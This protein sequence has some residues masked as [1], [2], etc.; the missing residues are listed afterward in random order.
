[1]AVDPCRMRVHLL[2]PVL[3]RPRLRL[4][5]ALGPGSSDH[6][7][8]SPER[9]ATAGH[10]MQPI[11]IV[12]KVLVPPRPPDILHRERLVDFLHEHIDR[13]LTLVSAPAGYGKTTLLVDFAH[14]TDLAVCWYTLD[15]ID[16]DSRVFAE[17]LVASL[18]HR[19]PEFGE[20]TRRAL[21]AHALPDDNL[22]EIVGTLVN[23]MVHTIPQWFVIILDDFHHVEHA[24]GVTDLLSTFLNYQPEHCHLIIASRTI[25]STLPFIHLAARRQV[26]GLGQDDLRF[27]PEE[28][29]L[30]FLQS[31]QPQVSPEE[32]HR[33]A[34]ESDG[35]IT[36]I[37]LTSHAL[38]RGTLEILRHA[39]TSAQPIHDYLSGEVLDAQDPKLRAFVLASSTLEEMSPA[40]CR[41]A[42]G[43]D[44]A[45]RLLGLL[46][47][48]NLFAERVVEE[49]QYRLRHHAFFRE[50]LQERLE[51]ESPETFRRLHRRAA[52]WYAE[53]GDA[54]RA[55]R[56]Y[57]ATGDAE[58]AAQLIS[59]EASTLL[60]TG[61]L[62]TLVAWA[63]RFPVETL[64]RYPSLAL[65]AAQA[66]LRTGRDRQASTWLDLAEKE[67][68][69]RDEKDLLT[70]TIST[71]ALLHYT[72]ARYTVGM[73][74]AEQALSLLSPQQPLVCE[75]TVE[76][77]R[78]KG[79]CQLRLGEYK[80]AE[81]CLRLALEGSREIRDVY[82]EVNIRQALGEC[83]RWMGRLGDGV[84]EQRAVVETCRQ[85][86]SPAALP[87]A[88]T[89]LAQS[90][91]SI[92]EHTEALNT[93][94]EAVDAAR[95]AGP[96]YS[97]A[98]TLLGLGEMLRDLGDPETAV[99][100]LASGLEIARD[101]HND[102]LSAYGHEA[103]ALARLYLG[104]ARQALRPAWEA[105]SVARQQGT[106]GQIGRCQAT[107]G[108]IQTE[109]G[110]VEKGIESLRA[111]CTVLEQTGAKQEAARA[112]LLLAY[113][114]L[115]G[116]Q[117][118]AALDLSSLAIESY[119]DGRQDHALLIEGQPV[120]PLLEMA[121]DQGIGG[122]ALAVVL[123]RRDHLQDLAQQA[124]RRAETATTTAPS[125]RA[126]GFGI[127][128]VERDGVM[129][130]TSDWATTTARYLFFY[131]LS[132]PCRTR[133]Q[134]GA[135]L[136]PDLR[137]TRLPG[138][139]HNTK[140][141]MQQALGTNP[142]VYEQQVYALQDDLRVWYDVEEF[143]RLL[144]RARR[145]APFKAARYMRQ[146][147]A[148]YAGDFLEDCWA[149][150]CVARRETLRRCYL[151]TIARLADWLL[152]H[153]RLEEVISL[154]QKGLETDSLREDFHCKLMQAYALSG[155]PEEAV[156]QYR[157]C[158]RIL[159]REL[160]SVPE[161][162]TEEL[163]IAIR[164]GL[165]RPADG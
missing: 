141:R 33:L 8:T 116:G 89:Q 152:E 18:A 62:E 137:A 58:A 38:G 59:G 22:V 113:A 74:I 108:L 119:L 11:P 63:Q 37:L 40:L 129:I 46:A 48:R 144:E 53:Q 75:A 149:D 12:T 148:L 16:R 106:M 135:D 136:W 54:D 111:A 107:L 52:V 80:D 45:D 32:A 51:T 69:K 25:P 3:L 112:R 105:A 76:A 162:E 93:Q 26:A 66:A 160:G 7:R 156:A 56:H 68:R 99:G 115:R 92:G 118:Q 161:P 131:L 35:W 28:I 121:V 165:F 47:Q 117:Q 159:K 97:Q 82:R 164:Q 96:G 9:L 154:L 86:G 5:R 44:E 49:G 103:M 142:V 27:S 20:R 36:G 23:E 91:Q 104:D 143:E 132:N 29:Q 10:S 60:G 146:A 110:E 139:F 42:L 130:P 140:Y 85:L 13:K 94:L 87:E 30:L 126:Y 83:L 77:Q 95:A 78:V 155:R 39:R 19:F 79:L 4:P 102:F 81:Q 70:L 2:G 50:F 72:Q 67:A 1:M 109:A 125:F 41:D 151:E 133:D 98:R 145:S 73:R 6:R 71:Q 65:A 158:V 138:T 128:R 64:Q 120:M 57:L 163:V 61:R 90:L 43:L 88:L 134:I 24:A 122:S 17:H 153:R 31:R 34:V 55:A 147:V 14:E 127:G 21:E 157:R 101:L 84:Q 150:W 123:E 15:P 114:L 124:L 100:I